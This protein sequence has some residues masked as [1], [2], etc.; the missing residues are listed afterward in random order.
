MRLIGKGVHKV[1]SDI[2]TE[3]QRLLFFI[4]ENNTY[5]IYELNAMMWI[6]EYTFKK[7]K[8]EHTLHNYWL[9]EYKLQVKWGARSP[10]S[11]FS[12]NKKY[13]VLLVRK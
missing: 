10:Q 4:D 12:N 9:I 13:Q 2:Q 6:I 3:K 5:D 8:Q 11:V 1:W 7:N